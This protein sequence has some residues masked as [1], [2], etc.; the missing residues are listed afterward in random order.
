MTSHPSDLWRNTTQRYQ[1]TRPAKLVTWSEIHAAPAGY[2]TM[3][4][5]IVAIVE[6]ADKTRATVQL[7]DVQEQV[8]KHGMALRPVFRKMYSPEANG[9]IPYGTKYTVG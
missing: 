7:T 9:V 8:L 5:Y 6:F 2:E 3:A 1:E 4:P